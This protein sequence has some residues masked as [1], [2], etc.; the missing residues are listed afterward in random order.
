MSSRLSRSQTN[1][2]SAVDANTHEG[3]TVPESTH[4]PT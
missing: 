3:D 1:D 4:A 2:M